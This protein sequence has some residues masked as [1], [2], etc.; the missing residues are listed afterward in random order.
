MSKVKT[1]TRTREFLKQKKKNEE[2]E[3]I[4]MKHN[5]KKNSTKIFFNIKLLKLNLISVMTSE[6][7]YIQMKI[8]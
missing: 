8:C 3:K 5:E 1:K 4:E 2:A 7:L 6:E